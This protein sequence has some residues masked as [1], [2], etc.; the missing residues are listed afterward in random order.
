MP[1]CISM[2]HTVSIYTLNIIKQRNIFDC[3]ARLKLLTPLFE[4]HMAEMVMAQLE[5]EVL[6]VYLRYK[7]IVGRKSLQM[8]PLLI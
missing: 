4:G 3:L 7:L 2:R 8:D 1:F 5:S 6:L